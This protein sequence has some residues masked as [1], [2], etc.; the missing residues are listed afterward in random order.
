MLLGRVEM[1]HSYLQGRVFKLGDITYVVARKQT[2]EG[3]VRCYRQEGDNFTI[4][5]LPLQLVLTHI[6][7]STVVAEP[8]SY[9]RY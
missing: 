7:D 4:V 5:R 9:T 1:R 3:R 6:V 2:E 8:V